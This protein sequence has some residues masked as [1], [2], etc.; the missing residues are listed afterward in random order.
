MFDFLKFLT[1]RSPGLK[2]GANPDPILGG[3]PWIK[4]GALL[5]ETMPDSYSLRHKMSRPGMQ[6]NWDCVGWAGASLREYQEKDETGQFTDYSGMA[7]YSLAKSIDGLASR[8]TYLHMA[9]YVPMK[10]GTVLESDYPERRIPEDPVMPDVPA[11]ALARAAKRRTKNSLAVDVGDCQ[12]YDGI[13]KTIW[14]R[15]MPVVIGTW[16]KKY[17]QVEK[18]GTLR[19]SGP[20]AF[21][22]ALLATGYDDKRERL[23][24]MNWW[25]EGWGDG[26]FAQLPYGTPIF[27][28]GWTSTDL[29][30]EDIVTEAPAKMERR[31]LGK[32]QRNALM[33]QQAVYRTF[34]PTDRARALAAREW[35]RLVAA[36]SYHGFTFTDVVNDLYARSRGR[37]PIFDLAKPKQKF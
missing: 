3:L 11:E 2:G 6:M 34:A 18:D 17:S 10:F 1:H 4:A 28:Q 29:P 35:F 19:M 21:G 23:E 22:H 30:N 7:V 12:T 8:G 14:E 32:E 13:K 33:L 26:G 16:W 31:D 9:T 15:K 5:P 25:G 36:V 20:D 27:S 24:F 37:S